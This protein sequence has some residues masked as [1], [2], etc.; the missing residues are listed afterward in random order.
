[1]FLRVCNEIVVRED[2]HWL[3]VADFTDITVLKILKA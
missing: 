1:M 2:D 3:L